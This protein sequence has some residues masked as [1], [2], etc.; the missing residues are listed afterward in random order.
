[1]CPT[2]IPKHEGYLGAYYDSTNPEMVTIGH[3]QRMV[4]PT[5]IVDLK[6]NG[7]W[8]MDEKE[9]KQKQKDQKLSN[10]TTTKDKTKSQLLTELQS[11]P[12]CLLD[13][14]DPSKWTTHDLQR[15]CKKAK[16]PVTLTVTNQ[17]SS[18]GGKGHRR[19]CCKCY[20]NV[21]SSICR[22]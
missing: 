5:G 13:S 19:V 17:K 21:D 7:P 2:L 8:W 20:G 1:M 22:N 11:R 6:T 9:R 16:N 10:E 12:G 3:A 15:I 14:T 4:F 18:R